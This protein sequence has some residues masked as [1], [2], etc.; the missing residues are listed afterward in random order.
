MLAIL[1]NAETD[2]CVVNIISGGYYIS[3]AADRIVAQPGTI[4]GSIGVIFGKFVLEKFLSNKL[5]ITHDTVE[6]VSPSS[7]PGLQGKACPHSGGST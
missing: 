1:I 4:T 6:K 5:G 2:T 3:A 7:L